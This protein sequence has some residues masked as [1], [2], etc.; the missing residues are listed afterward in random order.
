[1]QS[2]KQQEPARIRIN[3]VAPVEVVQV[4]Q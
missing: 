2:V 4:S 1:L 3:Q